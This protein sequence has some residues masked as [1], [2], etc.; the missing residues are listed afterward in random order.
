MLCPMPM[1]LF[2]AKT[3]VWGPMLRVPCHA[4]FCEEENFGLLNVCFYWLCFPTLLSFYYKSLLCSQFSLFPGYSSVVLA[5]VIANQNKLTIISITH[6]PSTFCS[7]G[8]ESSR[9]PYLD[10]G[11]VGSTRE[12][13]NKGMKKRRKRG[14]T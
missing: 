5:Q 1:L 3:E 13:G 14:K 12:Q 2:R 9:V 10:R 11:N 4:W 8:G 6:I 7:A